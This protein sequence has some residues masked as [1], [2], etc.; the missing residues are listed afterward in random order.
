MSNPQLH[1]LW[2]LVSGTH[3]TKTTLAQ[4]SLSRGHSRSGRSVPRRHQVITQ[5][6]REQQTLAPRELWPEG[7]KI[8]YRHPSWKTIMPPVKQK[9]SRLPCLQTISF[10]SRGFLPRAS[11]EI[12]LEFVE[13]TCGCLTFPARLRLIAQLNWIC[14]QRQCI[15]LITSENSCS[16]GG[17]FYIH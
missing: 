8:N 6:D 3:Q 11:T 17:E 10:T 16:C 12:A 15:L 5:K 4:R 13:Q 2:W 7:Q 9:R 1:K 14:L